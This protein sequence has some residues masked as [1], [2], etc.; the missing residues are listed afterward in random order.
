MNGVCHDSALLRLYWAGDNLGAS[1]TIKRLVILANLY[2][3]PWF[4]EKRFCNKV[5]MNSLKIQSKIP[6]LNVL[7]LLPSLKNTSKVVRILATYSLVTSGPN[8]ES[9]ATV[10]SQ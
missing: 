4:S 10:S 6:P 1:K 5:Q 2:V 3:L 9:H 8:N 7:D